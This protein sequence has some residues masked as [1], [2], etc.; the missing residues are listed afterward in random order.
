MI[1]CVCNEMGRVTNRCYLVR[2]RSLTGEEVLR[3]RIDGVSVGHEV[4]LDE[5]VLE[6]GI[7]IVEAQSETSRSATIITVVR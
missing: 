3:R 6:S 5:L 2:V 7:Y 4:L 1:A